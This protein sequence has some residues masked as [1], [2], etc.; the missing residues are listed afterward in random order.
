LSPGD[1]DAIA[2]RIVEPTARR[3]VELLQRADEPT[4]GPQ[5]E[6]Q[7]RLELLELVYQA[8]AEHGPISGNHLQR[9]VRRRRSDVGDTLNALERDG[10]LRRADDGRWASVQGPDAPEPPE[11]D[12]YETDPYETNGHDLDVDRAEHLIRDNADLLH[13]DIT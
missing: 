9:K 11:I 13:A 12:P 10:R 1:L 4:R 3:V 8:V 5:D 6:E 2:Q 7:R